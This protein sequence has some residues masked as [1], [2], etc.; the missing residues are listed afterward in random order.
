MGGAA[1]QPGA[2]PFK[3]FLPDIM[4]WMKQRRDLPFDRINPRHVR[5]L[6]GIAAQAS[7]REILHLGI[8]PM[9]LGDDVVH[10]K[11]Q[12]GPFWAQ[13]AVLAALLC[14]GTHGGVTR[15]MPQA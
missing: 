7:K 13:M 10:L 14:A 5:P 6:A 12:D 2:M 8:A 15:L 4:T 9:L 3:M 1:K 11:W